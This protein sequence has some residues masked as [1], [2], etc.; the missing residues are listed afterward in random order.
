MLITALIL[1]VI[2]LV[3]LTI[4]LVWMYR[5]N[6]KLKDYVLELE[7]LIPTLQTN[8]QP[9][10]QHQNTD[11]S[12]INVSEY[13]SLLDNFKSQITEMDKV[14]KEKMDLAVKNA[15]AQM[16][17][18]VAQG[19]SEQQQTLSTL[20]KQTQEW[21]EAAEGD[22]KFRLNN[23]LENF[24]ANMSQFFINAEQKSLESIN[25]ELKSARNLIDSYKS[26][27]LA[28]IEENIVAVLERTMAIVLKEKLNLNDQ[29]DL[30]YEALEKAKKEKFLE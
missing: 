10:G 11:L 21:Q 5:S 20:G 30:V 17:Q 19:K 25:L 24:E 22:I 8:T 6:S 28:I 13:N 2:V 3:I 14:Y 27:Q 23:F 7:I 26:Q 12:S 15:E 18:L 9:L 16:L 1:L 4:T 29:V